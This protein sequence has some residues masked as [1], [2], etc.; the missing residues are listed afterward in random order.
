MRFLEVPALKRR[1]VMGPPL[2][3]AAG[4]SVAKLDTRYRRRVP[5][6]GRARVKSA[7]HA[8]GQG[9]ALEEKLNL[10]RLKLSF[11]RKSLESGYQELAL[12]TKFHR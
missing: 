6:I 10:G 2:R 7:R 4:S 3:G 9:A 12:K 8:Q 1:P 11:L 5:S